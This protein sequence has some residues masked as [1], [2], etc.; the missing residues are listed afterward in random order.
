MLSALVP[1]L[2]AAGAFKEEYVTRTV[3]L[4]TPNQ[5]NYMRI[6]P[7]TDTTKP[8]A[9]KVSLTPET[10]DI[11]EFLVIEGLSGR[12]VSFESV[13]YPGTYLRHAESTFFLD[14]DDKDWNNGNGHAVP[15]QDATFEGHAASLAESKESL[16]SFRAFLAFDYRIGYTSAETELTVPDGDVLP[17][18]VEVVFKAQYKGKTI[19]LKATTANYETYQQNIVGGSITIGGGAFAEAQKYVVEDGLSGDVRTV[20]LRVATD[21]YLAYVCTQGVCSVQTVTGLTT[22]A[23]KDAASWVAEQSDT[24][25]RA[26]LFRATGDAPPITPMY[27]RHQSQNVVLSQKVVA[28]EVEDSTWDVMTEEPEGVVGPT[29]FFGLVAIHLALLPDKRVLAFGSPFVG[30]TLDGGDMTIWDKGTN[31]FSLL[32]GKFLMNSFCGSLAYHGGQLMVL[33]GSFG[34]ERAMSWFNYADDSLTELKNT[35]AY[36]RWYSTLVVLHNGK[37]LSLGGAP[38]FPDY[39]SDLTTKVSYTPE[40]YDGV[41]DTWSKLDGSADASLQGAFGSATAAVDFEWWYPR[42]YAANGTEGVVFGASGSKAWV[43]NTAA[44]GTFL[45]DNVDLGYYAG[46]SC[47]SVM[48]SPGK[49][50][51]VGGGQKHDGDCPAESNGIAGATTAKILTYSSEDGGTVKVTDAADMTHGRHWGTAVVLPTGEVAVVGGTRQCNSDALGDWVAEVEIWTPPTDDGLGSWRTAA[52]IHKPR[53]YHSTAMLLGDGTVLVAGGGLP[54]DTPKR[55]S[56]VF[57]PGY[58]YTHGMDEAS[59]KGDLDTPTAAARPVLLQA[60]ASPAYGATYTVTLETYQK[61][62]T[63]RIISL[64]TVTHSHNNGQTAVVLPYDQ[65]INSRDITVTFPTDADKRLVPGYYL[66]FVVNEHGVPSESLEVNNHFLHL[67][68]P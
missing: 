52:R 36:Q 16:Y 13:K 28:I 7:Q 12:G 25:K 39:G 19:A 2:L 15:L 51:I 58:L 29:Q 57:S 40:L 5:G 35:V 43:F 9:H 59:R 44:A 24:R 32:G 65:P 11:A 33:G 14:Q 63:V 1:V 48:Y 31:K 3:R 23:E 4:K 64:G 53:L 22:D 46:S 20:S 68:K 41:T 17:W 61:I 47:T 42:G 45:K 54:G 67:V 56:E 8:Y 27:M 10:A 66:L 55:D 37:M 50:L 26:Y 18:R 6:V 34:G 38:G 21:T 62:D 30:S 49:V 60:T